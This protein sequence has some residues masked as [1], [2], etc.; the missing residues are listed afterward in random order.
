VIISYAELLFLKA[1]FAYKGIVAAG[2]AAKNYTDAITASHAQYKLTVT[3]EYLTAN[4]LKAGADGFTQ[5]M[6]Q[7]WIAL[8]GQGLEAWTEF[9]RTGIPTLQPPLLNTNQNIIPTRMP[10]PGSEESLN[11]E[12][13]SAALSSQGGKND[14]KMKLWFAK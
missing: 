11:L 6:E 9:R 7:K 12:N 14:M 10:Y 4:A 5:I 3:P 1:E 13:F 8:Y 2:E